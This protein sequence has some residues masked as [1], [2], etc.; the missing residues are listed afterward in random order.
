MASTSGLTL[1]LEQGAAGDGVEG[2]EAAVDE[3]GEA[4]EA[5]DVERR[6][7]ARSS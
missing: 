4:P 5:L 7:I 2:L 1:Q 6:G 3:D